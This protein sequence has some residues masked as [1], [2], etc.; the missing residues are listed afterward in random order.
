MNET[1]EMTELTVIPA[2]SL[3]TILAN[4]KD[5]ILGK[6]AAKVAAFQPDI[7]THAGR[8]EMRSLAA[9]IARAKVALVK[10]GKSL[11]EDWRAATKAVNTECNTIEARMDELRDKVRAPLTAWENAEKER[12]AAHERALADIVEGPGWGVVET[13]DEIALRVRYLENYPPRDWQEFKDRYIATLAAELDRARAAHATAMTRET[14]ARELARLRAE[15]AERQ[16]QQQE[17]ERIA[18]EAQIA[19]DAADRARREAEAKAEQRAQAERDAAAKRALDAAEALSLAEQER[20]LADAR[21]KDVA[22]RADR[23]RIEAEAK[24]ERDRLAAIDAERRRVAEEAEYERKRAEVRAADQAHRGAVNREAMAAIQMALSVH[25]PDATKA[26]LAAKAVV[27]AIA[28]TDVP[29]VS[30]HY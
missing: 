25:I 10:I 2:S 27:V 24:A 11:T 5:D 3:P 21:A 17:Q 1:I 8:E 9:Q 12:V 13:S 7:S 22:E 26:G 19:A 16:R 20:Q 30:I 29:H 4:D 6:L 15:E 14:E 28:K 18:R 23:D